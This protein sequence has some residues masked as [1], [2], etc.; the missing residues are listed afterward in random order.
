LGRAIDIDPQTTIVDL[1]QTDASI[2]PGN[3]G[4]PLVNS[5]GEVV[6]INTAGIRGSQGIGFAINIDDA[7]AIAQQLIERGYVERGFLGISPVNLTPGLAM[8][9]GVPAVEGVVVARVVDGSGASEAG[10]QEQDV[11]VELSG[12]P[13]R[14]TGDLS[15]FLLNHLP[16]EEITI[17]YLRGDDED[18][19]K[20]TL[21]E[22]PGR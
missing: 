21:G 20:A 8:Q 19:E 18:E 17:K 4:G 16:G 5:R 15:K 13:I 12:E 14:N 1:I 2:N 3:S 11:I 10:I 7:M 22:R 6:G 9:I